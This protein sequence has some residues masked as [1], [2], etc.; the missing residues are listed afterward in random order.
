MEKPF[1]IWRSDVAALGIGLL[2]PD[3]SIP[4]G[5]ALSDGAIV[6]ADGWTEKNTQDLLST[7]PRALWLM[8]CA[9]IIPISEQQALEAILKSGKRIAQLRPPLAKVQT[10]QAPLT[11]L[12]MRAF[13]HDGPGQV[14]TVLVR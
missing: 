11:L 3:E 12:R 14:E 6:F 13:G 1:V 2:W 7:N 9:G 5:G 10:V 8:S 4:P